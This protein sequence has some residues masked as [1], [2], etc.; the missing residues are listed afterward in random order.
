MNKL[1]FPDNDHREAGKVQLETVKAMRDAKG[2]RKTAAAALGVSLSA[3]ASRLC[4]I[5][6]IRDA[7]K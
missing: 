4:V 3:L 5:R 1:D 6:R 7:Q 2:D